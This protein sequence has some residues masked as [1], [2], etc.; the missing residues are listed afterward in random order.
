MKSNGEDWAG[1]LVVVAVLLVACGVI[2]FTV[3]RTDR[4][5]VHNQRTLPNNEKIYTIDMMD[6]RSS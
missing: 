4:A 6:I 2:Y 3:N 1:C 5:Q